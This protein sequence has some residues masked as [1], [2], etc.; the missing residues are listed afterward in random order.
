MQNVRTTIPVQKN[1]DTKSANNE[2]MMY[3][4]KVL[5][6]VSTSLTGERLQFVCI[7][8]SSLGFTEAKQNNAIMLS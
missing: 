4:N 8:I 2:H 7:V 6:I 5:S 3:G 1:K